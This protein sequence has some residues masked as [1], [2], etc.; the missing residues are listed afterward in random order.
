MLVTNIEQVRD[1]IGGAIRVE[2]TFEILEPYLKKTE[3][4]LISDLIG[5][6]QLTALYG[7][8]SGS[9]LKLQE[10]V[11]N[12]II[13]NGYLDGW[14]QGFYEFSGSGVGKAVVKDK[15]ESLFRYQEDNIQKD[16]VRKADESTERLMLFLE[17][18]AS[19]FPLY[20][21]SYVYAQNFAYLISTPGALQRAL[22]EVS[23]SFRMYMVLR[24][25][26]DRVENA[27][28][29]IVSG[30]ELYEDLKLKVSSGSVMD[31]NYKKLLALAQDYAAP[32]VLLEAMPWIRVQFTPAG[33]RILSVLNNLQDETPVND[34]QTQWLME[35]LNKRID[36]AKTALRMFL[37]QVASE[38]V[39]PDYFHSD[40]YR[41]PGSRQWNMPD[42]EGKKHF[43]L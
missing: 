6:E 17:M 26:M 22:P 32:A 15:K 9:A 8:L 13:W 42:N 20:K 36:T 34:T 10:L 1:V 12:A 23:K 24:G 43:R 21:N 27:T 25:Y 38:I 33:I 18:N 40:M 4:N 11:R 30:N 37:N 7:N 28:V 19:G 39:F 31:S 5:Q 16:I 41:A 3:D 14:Y 29:R 2:N 35:I